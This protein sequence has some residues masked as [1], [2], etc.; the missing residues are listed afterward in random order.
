[1]LTSNAAAVINKNGRLQVFVRGTD[2]AL[3]TRVQRNQG[4]ADW[5][6]WRPR[7]AC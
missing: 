3:Y 2:N 7:A 1:M 4:S 6:E 5:T